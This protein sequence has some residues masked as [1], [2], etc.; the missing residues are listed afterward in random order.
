ML[1]YNTIPLTNEEAEIIVS[2]IKSHESED[3][4]DGVWDVCMKLIDLL[5]GAML[6]V[7]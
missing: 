4:P 2:F 7:E 6:Y 1:L 5:R 3:I